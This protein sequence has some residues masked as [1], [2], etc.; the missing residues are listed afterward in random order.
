MNAVLK[1]ALRY[2]ADPIAVIRM[3]TLNPA[4]YF[5]L[6]AHLG[7]IAPGRL[8][9]FCILDDLTDPSQEYYP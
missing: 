1:E 7:G 2:G 9:D 5:G 4:V 3:A 8:A 6:E